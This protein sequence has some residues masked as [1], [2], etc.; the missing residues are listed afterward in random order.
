MTPVEAMAARKV[1]VVEDEMMIAL[2]I[3]DVLRGLGCEIVGPVSRLESA[4]QIAKE[5]RFDAA[6]LDI[7][8]RGGEV[9][10]VADVLIERDIPFMFASGYGDWALPEAFRGLP[11]LPKPFT[12]DE[13]ENALR[14]LPK[15]A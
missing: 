10:P 4:L 15:A 14:A 7:T 5:A 11:R 1:F 3:E 2:M 9:Y 12:P 13:L 8:I 6:I